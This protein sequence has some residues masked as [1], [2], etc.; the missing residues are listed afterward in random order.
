MRRDFVGNVGLLDFALGADEALRQRGL[1]QQKRA[2]NLGC[3]ESAERAQRKGDLRL[4]AECGV[5]AGEDQAQA[6]VGKVHGVIIV[7]LGILERR[8]A[9]ALGF[10]EQRVFLLRARAVAA[11]EVHYAA[12]RGGQYPGGRVLRDAA[13]APRRERGDERILQRFFRPVERSAQSDQRCEDLPVLLA[14]YRFDCALG[15]GHSQFKSRQFTN[16]AARSL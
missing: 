7:I 1:R 11:R 5:A 3:G 6:V 10:V 4:G 2:G 9:E 15:I 13:L 14:K 16:R 8:G 12:P